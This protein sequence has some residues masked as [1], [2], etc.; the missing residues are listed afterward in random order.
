[1]AISKLSLF[2]FRN[3]EKKEITFLNVVDKNISYVQNNDTEMYA[4]KINFNN[5][6]YIDWWTKIKKWQS[7]DCLKFSNSKNIIKPQSCFVVTTHMFH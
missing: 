4:K 1:M 5:N 7:K 3:H 6:D 2:S